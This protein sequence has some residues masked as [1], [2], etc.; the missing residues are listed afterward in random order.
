MT[1]TPLAEKYA[2]HLQEGR[3]RLIE[4]RQAAMDLA[5][6]ARTVTQFEPKPSWFRRPSSLTVPHPSPE[7]ITAKNVARDSLRAWMNGVF[8]VIQTDLGF[9]KAELWLSAPTTTALGSNEP[10]EHEARITA[11]RQLVIELMERG[12]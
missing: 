2:R 5:N 12:A 6:E 11:L 8:A 10:A 1:D 3:K 7:L 4:W 9:V